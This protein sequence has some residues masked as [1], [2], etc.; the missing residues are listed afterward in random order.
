[1]RND[2]CLFED[3]LID[4]IGRGFLGSDLEE[5]IAEC[6]PCAELHLVAGAVLA[7][8]AEMIAE[9]PVPPSGRVWWRMRLRQRQEAEGKARRSLVVGQALTLAVAVSVLIFLFGGDI[10]VAAR[11][12]FYAIKFSALLLAAA[13]VVLMVPIG[14]WYA[15]RHTRE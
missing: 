5:H 12:A 3:E 14:G 10:V 2:V 4:A 6:E 13:A 7:D 1:M 11:E 9:A 8:R 15:L